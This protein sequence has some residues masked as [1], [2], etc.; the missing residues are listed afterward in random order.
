ME[1]KLTD[2]LNEHKVLFASTRGFDKKPRIRPAIFCYEDEGALYFAAAKNEEYYGEL[3]LFPQVEFSGLDEKSKTV[4]KLTGEALFTEDEE[5]VSRCF[6]NSDILKS[7]FLS[8]P[9]MIIAYFLKDAIAEFTDLMTG[10]T[11]TVELGE[12][13]NALIGIEFKKDK[14]LRDRLSKILEER[15]STSP[16]TGSDEA[17]ALQKLYDGALLYFAETAKSL[18][19]RMNIL[20][21]EQALLYETYDERE[22]Y[23]LKAKKLIGNTLITKPEDLTYWLNKETLDSL[24]N[25]K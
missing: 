25:E 14:E 18:W 12:P 7:R 16:D 21:I 9:E 19:P 3:S 5:I 4:L 1:K 10:E 8:E 11:S 20:Q 13:G 17:L 15:S 2:F 6:E 24:N 22:E 23:T